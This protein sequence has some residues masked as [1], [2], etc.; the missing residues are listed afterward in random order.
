M[1][2]GATREV[3]ELIR[4]AR[5]EKVSKTIARLIVRQIAEHQL[6]PGSTLLPE[7][8]MAEQYGVGR[9]SVREALRMLE[10]G[11]L[12]S[13]RQGVG[14]GPVVAAPTGAEFAEIM[15]LYLQFTGTRVDQLF[16]AMPPL[17]GMVA[18]VAAS[19]VAAEEVSREDVDVL[20]RMADETLED[21]DKETFA[22]HAPAFHVAIASLL[23]NPV[24]EL[25]HDGLLQLFIERANL[26]LPGLYDA[27]YRA[28]VAQ[29]HRSVAAAIAAGDAPGALQAMAEHVQVEITTLL[30]A[31]PAATAEPLEW[32]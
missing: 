4:R 5:S 14:G 1:P 6:P 28:L 18:Y 21:L 30:E 3:E 29:Q 7:Q 27:E 11:G 23:G 32:R 17:A 31:N 9:A 8:A 26:L 20:T 12:I 22:S 25:L 24:L 13:I 19:R 16:E 15:T 10:M 2:I